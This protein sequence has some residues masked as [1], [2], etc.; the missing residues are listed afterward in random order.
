[1]SSAPPPSTA[2]GSSAEAQAAAFA[3]DPRI[4]FLKETETWRYEDD[5]GSEMEYDAV[6]GTWVPLVDEDLLKKQQAAYSVAG[7]DEATPAAP[8]LARENKKRKEPEDYTSA[9]TTAGPS[10]KRG[11][12]DKKDKPVKSKNTAVYVTGLPLDAEADEI[13]ERFSK[14]GVIEEDDDGDPKVKLYAREDGS[15]SGEALVVYFKEDSVILA[16]NLLD[17]AELRF[18]DS[19]SVMKVQKAEFGHKN[20]SGVASGESQPRK[21]VDKK[22][23]SRRIGKMQKKLLE[24]DD[25]DGFG[26]SKMEEENAQVVNRNSRVVVLKHMFTLKE[27]EKDASLLLDLKEDVRE[28][29]STLGEVTNVVLYDKEADG[30]MTVKFRDP[31]SAQACILKMSGRFFDGRRVEASLYAGKQRFKRS[32]ASDEIEGDGDEAEKQRLDDF[33]SWLMTEGD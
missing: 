33:A 3:E 12:N 10:S 16:V 15:F 17:D 23:A 1:M 26:P 22:K 29:C 24:W 4:Y 9:T 6:K 18:G 13:I 28:E 32:G 7:V 11:K 8:V 31:L 21:T 25:E 27:L 2:A 14:C 20:T 30:V 19:S 5:D